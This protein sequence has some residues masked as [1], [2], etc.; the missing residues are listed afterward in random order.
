MG[1]RIT[2]VGSLFA[3]NQLNH[4]QKAISDSLARL[5][6]G[7]AVNKPTDD[8]AVFS[9]SVRLD[10]QVRGYSQSILN[11]NTAN[12]ILATASDAIGTQLEIA[13]KIREIAVQA[14][15]GTLQATDR[16]GLN[17][18][19]Q[20]LLQEFS[21]IASTASFNN[22]NLLD[23]SFG[24][25]Q[26]QV[27]AQVNESFGVQLNNSTANN[28]F[29]EQIGGGTFAAR[30]TYATGTTPSQTVTADFNG[31][32]KLDLVEADAG[33]PT[34]SVYLGNGD[35][36]FESRR[37]FTVGNAAVGLAVGDLNGDGIADV[38]TIDRNDNT[39]SILLGNGDG[40]F[41]PRVTLSAATNLQNIVLTDLN[42]DGKLD[43]A[44][45]DGSANTVSIFLGNGD[46]SFA[47]RTT[48]AVTAAQGLAT[49]DL[50]GD[51][52]Q[53]LVVGTN[54]AATTVTILLGNGNGSFQT[55]TIAALNNQPGSVTTGDI[56][57][58]GKQ[59]I[60]VGTTANG[61][62]V[63]TGLGNGTFSSASAV[64]AGAFITGLQLADLNGD[65]RSD[66]VY[67][68][69][70][71]AVF[72]AM[73]NGD[74]TFQAPVTAGV[75]GNGPGGL[76]LGDFNKDGVVDVAETDAADGTLSVLL[77]NTLS[78]SAVRDLNVSTQS[79]AQRLLFFIDNS[80][81][82]L[83]A[84]RTSIGAYQIRLDQSLNQS[85]LM[86]QNLTDARHRMI[87]E[88]FA[89]D[90]ASLTRNQ[91]LAQ[92]QVA[93]LGQANVAQQYLLKLFQ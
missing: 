12:S 11:I 80:I 33:S 43:I 29:Q 54:A 68:I 46:G 77:A 65:G 17:T 41:K 28:V 57:G 27:G 59:D 91:I 24:S 78:T 51:G 86:Q 10:A 3:Q 36:T 52:N 16:A 74:G 13:N 14:S 18:E 82:T 83:K 40:S 1:L 35:G 23:G 55:S 62:S 45:A 48:V 72:S 67:S 53:D 39:I 25:Q 85:S 75:L 34:I 88:D 32:G 76:V 79:K 73:G 42:H 21:R 93:V 89:Q 84:S 31:D 50:N 49:A 60:V 4:T 66:I 30:T 87:D 71:K 19:V 26:V 9:E 70:N 15:S 37:T 38:A 8:M 6:T 7:Q 22:I 58:D 63:F 20:S 64:A 90:T 44:T 5:S 47:A 61:L 2:T 81:N 69:V 56:N 92:A